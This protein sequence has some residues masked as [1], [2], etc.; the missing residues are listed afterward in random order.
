M[1]AV[2]Q[3]ETVSATTPLVFF[4][5][6]IDGKLYDLFSLSR[7]IYSVAI[8]GGAT[9]VVADGPL[10]LSDAPVGTRL[11]K[12]IYHA[13][14]TA[15][16]YTAGT[17]EVRW[18]Y[19][20]ASTDPVRENRQ[21][22]EVVDKN[23]FSTG[24]LYVGYCNSI[25]LM[26]LSP[27]DVQEIGD[28]QNLINDASRRIEA[29][30]YRFFE[31]RLATQKINGRGNRGLALNEPIIG[32]N[33]LEIESGVTGLSISLTEVDLDG[34]RINARH[35]NGLFDPDDRDDPRIEIERF[36]GLIFQSLSI[37]PKGPQTIHVTGV[38][39]YTDP[40]GGP[41]GCTPKPLFRVIGSLAIKLLQDPFGQDR[42]VID[43]FSV[44]KAKTRDQEVDYAAR[45]S[46]QISGLTGDPFVD[47][48]L[49]Q[50]VRPAHYG[51]V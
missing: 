20:L 10:N 1:S 19:Q 18:R 45:A 43:P 35:L 30:T 36:E 42:T 26:A 50:Y 28:V 27:F 39:G 25:D 6:Q 9:Q 38:F 5:F 21:R 33:K 14:F 29:L 11:G 41:M 23:K 7:S 46:I 12:G 4:A 49:L 17:Y 8:G 47:T 51:A 16:G 31:P 13:N 40:D 32:I 3:D 44:I 24:A 2:A 22:F 37:F 15:T 34:L 48:I